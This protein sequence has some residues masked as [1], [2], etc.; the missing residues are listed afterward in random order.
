MQIFDITLETNDLEKK[1]LISCHLPLSKQYKSSYTHKCMGDIIIDFLNIDIDAFIG[2]ILKS[3]ILDPHISAI[4]YNNLCEIIA[5]KTE[6]YLSIPIVNTLVKSLNRTNNMEQTANTAKK[7]LKGY[8][9]DY[10]NYF[11]SNKVENDSYVDWIF[12][13]MFDQMRVNIVYDEDS[14]K[15]YNMYVIDDLLSLLSFDFSN[16]YNHNIYFKIC[17]NCKNFFTPKN[18]SDEIYCDRIYKNG[19]TCKQIGYFEKEKSDPFKKLFTAARKTQ[20]ARIGYNKHIENYRDKHYKPWLK[21]AQEAKV[22]FEAN[23]DV[24]GFRQWIED[25]KNAF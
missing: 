1:Y 7:A 16:A 24:D 22:Q 8:Q 11:K 6:I 12:S 9:E 5:D 3:N 15:F 20:Y 17:Q 21:A 13:G 25:N 19:K 18:R 23:N 2:A 14:S 4:S 10:S